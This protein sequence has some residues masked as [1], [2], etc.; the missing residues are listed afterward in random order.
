MYV[1]S[2]YTE[3]M[4]LLRPGERPPQ[5]TTAAHVRAAREAAQANLAEARS[6]VRA[7]TP[8]DLEHGSLAALATERLEPAARSVV[9]ATTGQAV[10]CRQFQVEAAIRRLE[11]SR[12]RPM[13][14]LHR[15]IE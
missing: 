12:L 14:P 5:V 4:T 6:F 10:S 2:E 8:P 3:R 15:S 13:E 9:D 1:S 11:N 7:L